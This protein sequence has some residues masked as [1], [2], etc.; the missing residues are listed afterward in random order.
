MVSLTENC[1]FTFLGII[2]H[3]FLTFRSSCFSE[4]KFF[5]LRFLFRIFFDFMRWLERSKIQ[6]CELLFILENH[7]SPGFSFRLFFRKFKFL[8]FHF[9]LKILLWI[10]QVKSLFT[11]SRYC[12]VRFTLL[13]N[14]LQQ[15]FLKFMISG[16]KIYRQILRGYKI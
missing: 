10:S 6:I 13:L 15:V 11:I 14:L 12:S 7:D 4:F 8:V 5:N 16:L 1:I 9:I 3:C 2:F